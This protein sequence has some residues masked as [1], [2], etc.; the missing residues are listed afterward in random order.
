AGLL[1]SINATISGSQNA[2]LVGGQWSEGSSSLSAGLS[3][4]Q[5]IYDNNRTAAQDEAAR[6]GA[7]AGE[8][9]LRNTEQNVLLSVVEAYMTVL[10]GRELL[11]L[12]QENL[13]FFQAQLQSAQDR[14]EVGEGTRIDVAQAQARLA[15]GQAGLQAA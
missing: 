15:Q 12:R 14:L 3:Y 4:G 13:N 10:S 8:Y 1:P 11:A 5:T 2:A 6:A 9:E 7:E